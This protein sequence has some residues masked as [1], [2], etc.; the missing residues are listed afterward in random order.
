MTARSTRMTFGNVMPWISYPFSRRNATASSFVRP[1]DRNSA[2]ITF[3][4][5]FPK[6]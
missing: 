2:Q 6:S 5:Y 1:F 4:R 3:G